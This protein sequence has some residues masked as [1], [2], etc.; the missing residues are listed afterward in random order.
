MET[1]HEDI[2][3]VINLHPPLGGSGWVL[4]ELGS[5]FLSFNFLIL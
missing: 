1:H 5:F 4:V 3:Q 2:Y